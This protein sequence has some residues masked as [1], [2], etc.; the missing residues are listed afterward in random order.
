ML[1]LGQSQRAVLLPQSAPGWSGKLPQRR[2]PWQ[3][4]SAQK[5]T[6]SMRPKTHRGLG[7]EGASEH[8]AQAS[9][10]ARAGEQVLPATSKSQ[11]LQDVKPVTAGGRTPELA[12]SLHSHSRG[13]HL[14]NHLS[15]DFSFK[16]GELSWD[17]KG[18]PD[19]GTATQNRAGVRCLSPGAHQPGLARQFTPR[20]P[21]QHCGAE[22]P[23][24]L[25]SNSEGALR[26]HLALFG[27]CHG[28]ALVGENYRIFL[29]S[30]SSQATSD[31]G[32]RFRFCK[33]WMSWPHCSSLSTWRDRTPE[34]LWPLS[35]L[36]PQRALCE[37]FVPQLL[38][39]RSQ[40]P[41]RPGPAE[42][43]GHG[44][45]DGTERES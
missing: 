18:L 34:Q 20:Q 29:T 35:L 28:R 6:A 31:E 42:L 9:P 25:R 14:E 39:H 41:H 5:D 38:R 8:S 17:G 33:A 40:C 44:V 45:S 7:H 24:L 13:I 36:P 26:Q 1:L 27:Q 23:P 4:L 10:K 12:H 3:Q 11:D 37:G 16:D 19:E 32:P 30:L 15:T 2:R 43:H 21:S 22:P